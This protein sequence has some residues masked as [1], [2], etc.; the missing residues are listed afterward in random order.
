MAYLES[1]TFFPKGL[2][3]FVQAL[4]RYTPS[5]D[6]LKKISEAAAS[7]GL[8]ELRQASLKLQKL[9]SDEF[10]KGLRR[11]GAVPKRIYPSREEI[12]GNLFATLSESPSP[13]VKAFVANLAVAWFKP[14]AQ[15][16]GIYGKYTG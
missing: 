11:F 6:G 3:S 7:V 10:N 14:V 15:E 8:P 16:I 13:K 12:L 2:E 4:E 5:L 1:T 9:G